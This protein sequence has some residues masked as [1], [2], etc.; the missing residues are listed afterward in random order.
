MLLIETKEKRKF[1]RIE[2]VKKIRGRFC[3]KREGGPKM[4]KKMLILLSFAVLLLAP[5]LVLSDCVDLGH[6]T[7]WYA[8][9]AHTIIFYAGPRPLGHVDLWDCTV[10]PSS[11]IH[12]TSNYVCDSDKIIIDGEECTIMTVSLSSISF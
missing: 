11:M 12:L 6:S 8:Q 5:N 3:G 10:N 7:S 1:E 4:R 9:G 2:E